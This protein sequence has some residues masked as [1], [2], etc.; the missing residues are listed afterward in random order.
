MESKP[1]SG[2]QIKYD[3]KQLRQTPEK[4]KNWLEDRQKE[5]GPIL[6]LEQLTQQEPQEIWE[7]LQN[8]MHHGL[9][10]T[11]PHAKNNTQQDPHTHE[12]RKWGTEEER[13]KVSEQSQQ[14]KNP[15]NKLTKLTNKSRGK[16][17]H[18]ACSEFSM[19][20]NTRKYKHRREI[21]KS[22]STKSKQ[23]EM[24]IGEEDAK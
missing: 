10:T 8:T 21:R 22:E 12:H 11:Y 1:E 9:R 24:H 4:L 23:Y 20:G 19:P 17:K 16:T 13:E 3:V 15:R 5:T 18:N 6:P 2:A 7:H 14:C